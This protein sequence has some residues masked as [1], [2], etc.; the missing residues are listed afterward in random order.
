MKNEQPLPAFRK[1]NN[2]PAIVEELYILGWVDSTAEN[3]VRCLFVKGTMYIPA[4]D[5][6]RLLGKAGHGH[7]LTGI[8]AAGRKK[9]KTHAH[10]AIGDWRK[11][12]TVTAVKLP[13]LQERIAKMR[14]L[15]PADKEKVLAWIE[16]T[17]KPEV[18]RNGVTPRPEPNKTEWRSH[19]TKVTKT[20]YYGGGWVW[21]CND[22]KITST[23]PE[24]DYS[25]AYRE[26]NIHSL[27]NAIHDPLGVKLAA[28]R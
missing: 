25:D 28:L 16:H 18:W 26:A 15:H 21:G 9:I 27:K 6:D 13:A 20:E 8:P 3:S 19:R 2:R 7:T 22:C 12:E 11:A 23:N 17:Q 24:K 5:I 10:A 4:K 14:S 1:P